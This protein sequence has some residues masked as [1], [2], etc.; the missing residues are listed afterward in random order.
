MVQRK[1]KI[2]GKSTWFK[3][4]KKTQPETKSNQNRGEKGPNYRKR[5]RSE[6]STPGHEPN[7]DPN[8]VIFVPRTK[9]GG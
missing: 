3:G 7:R 6:K 5:N 4:R 9:G 2:T 1:K 8:T